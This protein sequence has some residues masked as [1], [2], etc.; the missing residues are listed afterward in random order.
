MTLTSYSCSHF[1]GTRRQWLATTPPSGQLFTTA[2]IFFAS[3]R[4]WE[5]RGF[6]STLA[7]IL[8]LRD[9]SFPDIWWS[10]SGGIWPFPVALSRLSPFP[11]SH[12]HQSNMHF[13]THLCPLVFF[14]L[15]RWLS[16][17]FDWWE[18][19]YL[20]HLHILLSIWA[21]SL[22]CRLHSTSHIGHSWSEHWT[23]IHS[24]VSLF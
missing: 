17:C 4:K 21:L 13:F 16:G 2:P 10:L 12:I 11:H 8:S 18:A 3:L 15:D 7:L 6:I 14:S 24:R 9:F 1:D 5:W 22:W 23:F 20:C 19:T